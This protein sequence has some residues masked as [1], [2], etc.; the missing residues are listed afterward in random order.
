MLDCVCVIFYINNMNFG[1]I[2]VF[3]MFVGLYISKMINGRLYFFL[4]MWG[5]DFSM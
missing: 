3:K 2:Y 4:I 5:L 1:E